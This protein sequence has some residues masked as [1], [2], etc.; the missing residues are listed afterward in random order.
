MS[1]FDELLNTGYDE[2][3]KQIFHPTRIDGVNHT[4]SAAWQNIE[5]GK[6]LASN[7]GFELESG[8]QLILRLGSVQDVDNLSGK[9]ATRMHDQIKRRIRGVQTNRVSIICE[10]EPENR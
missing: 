9:V 3:E 2:A 8:G 6:T 10:L 4:I 1:E 5:R 7:A